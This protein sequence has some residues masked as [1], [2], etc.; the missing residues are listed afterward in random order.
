MKLCRCKIVW[1]CSILC[2]FVISCHKDESAEPDNKAPFAETE[3]AVLS[4]EVSTD[5]W[6]R[7][8][9]LY[10]NDNHTKEYIRCDATLVRGEEVCKLNNVGLRLKGQTSRARPEGSTEGKHVAG[11]TDWHHFHFSLNAGKFDK[12]SDQSFLG[13][14]KVVL[15]F[16]KEDPSYVREHYCWDLAS[17]YGI[18]TGIKASYCRV[19]IHVAGDA[20]SV[21]Y[22]VYNLMENID[23]EYL[24]ERASQFGSAKGFLWKCQWGS[25]L[26]DIIDSNFKIDDNSSYETAYELKTGE[27]HFDEAKA[28]FR[29]F[30]YNLN[31]LE[32][33]EF[34]NWMDRVCDVDFLLKTYS[35]LV[36]V[37]HWDDYW[38]DMN[39]YYVYFNSKDITNYKFFLIPYDLDNTLGTCGD[40]GV[41]KDAGRQNPY[42]WGMAQCPLMSRI[43]EVPKY[44]KIYTKYLVALSDIN[45]PYFGWDASIRRIEY[46]HSMIEDYIK[47]DTGEDMVIRDR[48]ASWGS[49]PQYRILSMNDNNWFKVKCESLKL[50]TD[51]YSG[52][53]R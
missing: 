17:R 47:N 12:D 50:W 21:Y 35:M 29:N 4:I 26:K 31:H 14:E 22:G 36:T 1:L 25:N 46:W 37:G 44:R 7:L 20:Q 10:D 6:N 48:P 30:I 24:K 45:G 19:F 5:E 40:C 23:K 11:K 42:I 28:Q 27:D 18:W 43:L 52:M 49:Q 51:I 33:E 39:N 16:S 9:S 38:N 34:I 15:K 2:S 3:L 41:Q 32:G 8:L 53:D 13:R